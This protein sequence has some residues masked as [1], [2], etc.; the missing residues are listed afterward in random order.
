[1]SHAVVSRPQSITIQARF[2]ASK[3]ISL[4]WPAPASYLY[5]VATALP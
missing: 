2:G 1:M 3:R 5:S 4:H